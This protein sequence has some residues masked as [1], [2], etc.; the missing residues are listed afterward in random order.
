[1]LLNFIEIQDQR[2]SLHRFNNFNNCLRLFCLYLILT[3][4]VLNTVQ[5]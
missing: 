4:P 2:M 5:Q 3:D 1:M